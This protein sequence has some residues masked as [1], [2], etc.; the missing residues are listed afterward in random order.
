MAKTYTD[1]AKLSLKI[2][3]HQAAGQC[4]VL[5]N[6]CFDLLH[7]G[8]ISYLEDA[9]RHGDIIVVGLNS[10]ASV[11]QLKGDNRPIC[12]EEERLLALE[13]LRVVDYIIVFG[14]STCEQLLRALRPNVHA[15]GTDYTAENV[16]ERAISDELG[17]ET[18]ITGNPKENATK[19][20]IKKVKEN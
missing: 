20:M 15:K 6:G 4:V 19:T 17:I 10:D 7:G 9:R 14:E 11:R 2:K 13:S 18:V 3:E 16:P 12:N 1:L 5:T 8:H